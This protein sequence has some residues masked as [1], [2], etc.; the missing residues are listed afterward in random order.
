VVGEYERDLVALH[1]KQRKF[2]LKYRG[3]I[4]CRLSFIETYNHIISD[5][6]V[7]IL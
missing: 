7:K 3:K 6:P 5:R 4:T 2:R 1:H